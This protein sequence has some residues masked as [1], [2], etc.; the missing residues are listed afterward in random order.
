MKKKKQLKMNEDCT[1]W[2]R[3]A[4]KTSYWNQEKDF[5]STLEVLTNAVR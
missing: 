2:L 1:N 5:S 4:T 3:L